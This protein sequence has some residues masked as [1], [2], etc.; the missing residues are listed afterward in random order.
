V[1]LGDIMN[2][3]LAGA[4]GVIGRRL[5]VLLKEAHHEIA[6]T[7]R[8]A[9][10]GRVLSTLGVRPF[11]VDVL[12]PAALTEAVE[13]AAPDIIVHQLT[14][15]ASPPGTPGYDEALQKNARLRIEGTRNLMTA[16]KSAGVGRVIAQSVAF[17]YAP[18]EG[19]RV[20]SDPLDTKAQGMR[21]VSVAGVVALED[22][23]T[24]TSGIDGFVL[25]YGFLYGP[26]TWY[27]AKKAPPPAVHVDA[28]AH[29]ALL[30]IRKGE[31]GIYNIAE[32]DGAVSTEKARRE[33]GFDPS[34]RILGTA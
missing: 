30:A 17:V 20:E 16:A 25:R 24:K 9:A 23:V 3:F 18:G 6:G 28:A 14:D 10:K 33:L 29:A 4:T 27:A 11:V 15:L 12:D 32:D 34:F 31:P 21:A 5:V 22:A 19:A 26:G 7:T 8:T 13:A 1:P 2:V